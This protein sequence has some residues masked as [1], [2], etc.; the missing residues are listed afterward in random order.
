MERHIIILYVIKK[1]RYFCKPIR[2]KRRVGKK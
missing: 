1:I 2:L